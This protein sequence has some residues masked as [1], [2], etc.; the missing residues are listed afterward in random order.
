MRR[1]LTFEE[2]YKDY[3]VDRK[4]VSSKDF[5]K[6]IRFVSRDEE[7]DVAAGSMA[8]ELDAVA[9]AKEYIESLPTVDLN[10]PRQLLDVLS[11]PNRGNPRWNH[12]PGA[13]L[14]AMAALAVLT[15]AA[16]TIATAVLRR[17]DPV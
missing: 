2:T 3:L 13:W 10:Q 4:V 6:A 16:L 1:A 11:A 7:D 15:I 8:D 17:F 14:R 9:E 5:Q 12:Q